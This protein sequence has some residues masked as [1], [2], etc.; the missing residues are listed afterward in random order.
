MRYYFPTPGHDIENGK[1]R[2]SVLKLRSLSLIYQCNYDEF[3]VL[4]A[5]PLEKLQG[6]TRNYCCHALTSWIKEAKE[7]T[8]IARPNFALT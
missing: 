8:I 6:I 7:R 3:L 4:F 5:F 1:Y 2:P